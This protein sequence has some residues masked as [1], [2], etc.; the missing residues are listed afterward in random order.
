MT[1]DATSAA[2]AAADRSPMTTGVLYGLAAA[3]IWGAW[4]VVTRL[5]VQDSLAPLDVTL[6]RFGVAGLVLL[7][8]FWHRG[9]A[10]LGWPRALILATGAGVPYMLTTATGLTLAPASHAGVI[11]PSTMLTLSLIGA[12]LVLGERPD[13]LR[14]LGIAAILGGVCLIGAKGLAAGSGREWLG[15][16]L[17]VGSGALWATYTVAA[18]AWSVEPL[19]ATA[20]V[21]VLSLAL[22]LPVMLLAGPTS[23]HQAPVAVLATQALFQGLFAAVLALLFYSRAVARLG[24]GRGAVFAALVPGVAMLLAVALLGEQPGRLELL[25]LALVSL[26]MP[27][28]LGLIGQGRPPRLTV[29]RT[30][31]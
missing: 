26:G 31:A 20:L 16:L 5:G 25:G 22:L 12:W 30:S 3:L 1:L 10:G 6:L 8:V 21:S 19:H 13:W 4:P 14:L 9:L 27:A 7:P 28:G 23:L 24:A 2:G 17:F 11:V 15:D 18:R 29:R